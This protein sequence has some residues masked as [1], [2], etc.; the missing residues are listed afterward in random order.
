MVIMVKKVCCP[1]KMLQAAPEF[2]KLV[3][4][5]IP[6]IN[7]LLP[8]RTIEEVTQ[9][10]NNWSQIVKIKIIPIAIPSNNY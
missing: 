8:P 5:I 1:S 4:L 3:N 6:G 10:F 7:C 2:R 9:D